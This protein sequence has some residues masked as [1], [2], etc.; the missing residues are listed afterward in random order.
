MNC[1]IIQPA[2][3]GDCHSKSVTTVE[4]RLSFTP[5][6]DASDTYWDRYLLGTLLPAQHTTLYQ[7][8]RSGSG[9]AAGIEYRHGSWLQILNTYDYL[10]SGSLWQ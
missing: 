4:L 8:C 10:R 7:R 1:L 9:T 5:A 2:P 6:S 3:V